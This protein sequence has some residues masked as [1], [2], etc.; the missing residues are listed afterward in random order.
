MVTSQSATV[1]DNP[2]TS[3]LEINSIPIPLLKRIPQKTIKKT[4]LH[5]WDREEFE[6]QT[7][8]FLTVFNVILHFILVL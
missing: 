3:I 6:L 8:L 4:S 2:A 5:V 7:E 1:P